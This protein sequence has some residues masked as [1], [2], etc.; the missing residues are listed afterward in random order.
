MNKILVVE[1]DQS[2]AELIGIHLKLNGYQV[3]FAHN[4]LIAK[5]FLI[6]NAYDLII[7]DLMMPILNGFDLLPDIVSKNIPVIILSAKDQLQDK[8]KGFD[9]GADDY[10]TKPFQAIELMMRVRALLKRCQPCDD[11]YIKEDIRINFTNRQIT[12]SDKP[13]ELTLKEYD[14]LAYLVK[15]AGVA[16]SRDQL[17]EEVWDYAYIGNSRTVDMHVQKLR[18]KLQLPIETIYKYGYRLEK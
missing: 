5:N 11:L 6:E 8:I 13:I 12:K 16:L 1:D 3:E 4:G 9:L 15:N 2:I 17:L 14:L 18:Q 10:L 7:L